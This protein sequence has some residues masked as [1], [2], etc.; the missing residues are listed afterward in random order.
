METFKK[1]SQIIDVVK[2]FPGIEQKAISNITGLHASTVSRH[3]KNLVNDGYLDMVGRKYY[4]GSKI[5]DIKKQKM[6]V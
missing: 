5:T 6:E 2:D 3:C 4:I 1:S